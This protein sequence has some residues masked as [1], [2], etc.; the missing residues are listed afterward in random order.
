MKDSEVRNVV[1]VDKIKSNSDENG[2]AEYAEFFRGHIDPLDH[3]FLSL[4]EKYGSQ[5]ERRS[6]TQG[7]SD[8]T[9]YTLN[10]SL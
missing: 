9:E 4:G 2:A 6:H 8:E 3:V 7:I 5:D 10:E 1:K